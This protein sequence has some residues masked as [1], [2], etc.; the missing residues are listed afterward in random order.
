MTKTILAAVGATLVLA[1]A[2]VAGEGHQH[3]TASMD[4]KSAMM[5]E[6]MKCSVCSH[7]APHMESL[8]PVMKMEVVNLDNGVA[9]VHKVTDASKL[10][11]YRTVNA[12]MHAAGG[13]CMEMSDADAQAK[14]CSFCQGIRSNVKA[15][16][17]MSVGD[18]K[19]GDMMV[20]TS[21]DPAV[22]KSLAE[23]A[24]KCAMMADQM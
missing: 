19:N 18:T 9:I 1:G 10:A 21:G 15:G 20:L 22:Q 24:A 14:L 7:M 16:A 6:M 11:E 13:K 8:G 2:A 23:L 17:M 4:M 12:E 3:S 5:A